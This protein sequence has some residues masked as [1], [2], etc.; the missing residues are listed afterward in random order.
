M[1]INT[2]NLTSGAERNIFKIV[3]ETYF[4]HMIGKYTTTKYNVTETILCRH[5]DT[6]QQPP[7][8]SQKKRM[9]GHIH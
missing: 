2:K 1:Q 7:S 3:T 9:W 6:F 5:A 8:P 4:F